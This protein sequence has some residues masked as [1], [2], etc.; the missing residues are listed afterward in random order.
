[1][2]AEGALLGSPPLQEEALPWATMTAEAEQICCGTSGERHPVCP[3]L[4]LLSGQVTIAFRLGRHYFN[5][6]GL[7]VAVSVTAM[8]LGTDF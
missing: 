1:M 2:R 3:P 6:P 8:G 7:Q 5:L 4:T